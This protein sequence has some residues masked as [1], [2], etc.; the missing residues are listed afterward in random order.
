M[1]DLAERIERVMIARATISEAQAIENSGTLRCAIRARCSHPMAEKD[2]GES[3]LAY[4]SQMEV[5]SAAIIS[6]SK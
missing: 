4:A 6:G 3:A 2:F 1:R 5:R